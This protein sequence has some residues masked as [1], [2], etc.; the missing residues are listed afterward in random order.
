MLLKPLAIA[1]AGL[2]A[3]T[4]AF[5]L[6]PEISQS[7]VDIV[8]ALPQVETYAVPGLINLDLPCP[9]CLLYTKGKIVSD[10]PNHLQLA[11]SVDRSLGYD[12]LRVNDFT[13]YP[14]ASPFVETLRAP[15]RSDEEPAVWKKLRGHRP[16]GRHSPKLGFQLAAQ[17]SPTKGE[18]GLALVLLDLQ[19]IE[20][21]EAFVDGIPNVHIKLV[22]DITTGALV[23]GSIET[24]ESNTAIT[25]P[26]DKQRECNTALCKWLAIAKDSMAK[27]KG[28]PCHGKMRGGAKGPRPHHDHHH[29]GHHAPHRHNGDGN[30]HK[31]SQLFKNIAA[32]ILLPVA[33]G[34]VAGVSVSVIG[35]LIGTLIVSVWRALFRRPSHRRSRAHSRSHKASKK[36][37]AVAE[38]EEKAGLME[39][40]DAPP[41]YED[42]VVP[43]ADV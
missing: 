25:T 31:M 28:K 22:K 15:L 8:D 6:P 37:V 29:H 3:A 4:Q 11:F 1:A 34:I 17:Q 43:K 39:D 32:H 40:Q 26:L 13:L 12:R 5:L 2:A 16:H 30:H 18:D 35:M 9:G 42:E 10:K 23:I 19:I 24:T 41:S 27:M 38:V 33:L 36:E 7:D 20:V 21:G 14:N